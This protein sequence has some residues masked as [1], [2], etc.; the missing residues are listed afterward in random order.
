ML[1]LA[2]RLRRGR[3]TAFATGRR[4]RAA[5]GPLVSCMLRKIGELISVLPLIERL[6]AREVNVRVTSAR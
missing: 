4:D 5:V 3:N 1:L 6:R 2:R